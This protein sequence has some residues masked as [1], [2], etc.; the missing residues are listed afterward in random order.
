MLSPR[1]LVLALGTIASLALAS[2]S[3]AQDSY[4]SRP[5]KVIVALP[6]E[7]EVRCYDPATGEQLAKSSQ[8]D[9]EMAALSAEL[10]WPT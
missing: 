7:R 6:E 4:P 10:D 5:V 3:W 9:V 2:P 8:L 1:P